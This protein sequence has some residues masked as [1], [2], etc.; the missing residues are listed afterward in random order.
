MRQFRSDHSPVSLLISL[1]SPGG[2]PDPFLPRDSGL[3][4]DGGQ[5]GGGGGGGVPLAGGL[6]SMGLGG[7]GF[8]SYG[9]QGISWG[10]WNLPGGVFSFRR[11]WR[12][13]RIWWFS[14]RCWRTFWIWRLVF[15]RKH[16]SNSK[17][18]KLYSVQSSK[19]VSKTKNIV[20]NCRIKV[21][22]SSYLLLNFMVSVL[23]L[24]LLKQKSCYFQESGT[25]GLG[26]IPPGAPG[27]KYPAWH[28][29]PWFLFSTFYS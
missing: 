22:I 23:V 16:A 7:R 26:G 19:C 20:I 5:A 29:I 13:W 18:S 24:I 15:A 4:F 11:F 8:P 27:K 10:S 9:N 2:S 17:K 21:V 6:N 3:D 1:L 14:R 25:G 28:L 12:I